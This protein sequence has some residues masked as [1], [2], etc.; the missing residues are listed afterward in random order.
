MYEQN[1]HRIHWQRGMQSIPKHRG[2]REMSAAGRY[3]SKTWQILGIYWARGRYVFILRTQLTILLLKVAEE[4]FVPQFCT[5]KAPGSAGHLVQR[6]SVYYPPKI[7][8]RALMLGIDFSFDA[9]NLAKWTS[10]QIC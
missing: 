5:S 1:L 3:P 6:L 9:T 4:S 7:D 2:R 10:T 8:F